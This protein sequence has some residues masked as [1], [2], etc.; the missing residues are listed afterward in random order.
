MEK[1]WLVSKI[2]IVLEDQNVEFSTAFSCTVGRERISF[3]FC[4]NTNKFI[5]K[6]LV[7]VLLRIYKYK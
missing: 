4:L 2:I 5:N 3:S 1:F 7:F 6:D